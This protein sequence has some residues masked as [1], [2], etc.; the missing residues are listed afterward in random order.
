MN[1][2]HPRE[3]FVNISV[4]DLDKSVAFFNA[5]GFSF[6]PQFTDQNAA[7]MI[8]SDKSYFMLLTEA[9]F[10]RFT[11]R[12]ICDTT[13]TTEGLFALSCE[14][15]AEVDLM[16]KTALEMGGKPAQDPMDHGFMYAWSFYDLDGHHFEVFWMDPSHVQPTNG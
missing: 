2:Q 9:S 11:Q 4:K 5:L 8:V 6:N 16:V 3:L 13:T 15:R 12:A 1:L 10:R 14:S 7:C